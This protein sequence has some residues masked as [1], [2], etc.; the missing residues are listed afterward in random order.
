MF[1]LRV[2]KVYLDEAVGSD[3]VT[4]GSSAAAVSTESPQKQ[5]PPK[6][7][8]NIKGIIFDFD[9]TLFDNARL[10]FFLIASNPLDCMLIWKER[11]IRKRFT[12]C[13]YAEPELYYRAFFA[14]M[15][16]V[17]HRS[18]QRMQKWYFSQY[19][20]RM[21][22]VLERHFKPRLGVA[23]LMQRFEQ[24][25]TMGAASGKNIIP[26]IAIY[27]DYPFLKERLE[28]LEIYTGS[29]IPLYSPESFG[30]QKPA[31]RPFLSIAAD[32]G[33]TPEE[34]LIIGD[35]QETDGIG[36]FNA[37]MRFFCLETGRKRYVR[38]DPYRRRIKE[39]PHGP[40]LVMYAGRWE[41]IHALLTGLF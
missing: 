8:H 26:K 15:G 5:S 36:A 31:T 13:D 11:L 9:G 12:G 40:S 23:D 37:G 41:G 22:R 10:P 27:S 29:G 1:P 32:L 34:I 4:I 14:A 28:A 6:L 7:L 17:C 24:S 18:P 20:P 33:I 19:M 3:S 16:K 35:R 38:L 39:E 21:V 30:A 2:K 25:R